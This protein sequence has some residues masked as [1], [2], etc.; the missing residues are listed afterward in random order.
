MSSDS[1]DGGGS[2]TFSQPAL[3]RATADG[4]LDTSFGNNGRLI[5]VPDSSIADAGVSVPAQFGGLFLSADGLAIDAN[6]NLFVVS[7]FESG[8][9]VIQSVL[10]SGQIDTSFG[11]SGT[12][13][14]DSSA[15]APNNTTNI[16]FTIFDS[17]NNLV[18]GGNGLLTS[19]TGIDRLT[20][21]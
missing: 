9:F 16:E 6:D 12:Q 11:N 14:V 7:T 15:D 2:I 21:V 3:V 20:F 4:Q 18:V 10:A 13:V 19:A 1:F 5:L 8:L 17:N